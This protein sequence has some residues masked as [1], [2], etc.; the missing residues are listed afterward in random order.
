MYLPL[1]GWHMHKYQGVV[2]AI[3]CLV[4]IGSTVGVLH[5]TVVKGSGNTIWVDDDFIYPAESDGSVTKPYKTIKSALAVASNGDTIKVLPGTY[6][7]DLT[8]DKSITLVSEDATE[9]I[10]TSSQLNSY[11]IDIT[12]SSVSIEGFT[13]LD[14]TNTTHRRAVVHISSGVSDVVLTNNVINH[15]KDARGIFVNGAKSAIIT[16]NIINDTHGINVEHS[17]AT[18]IYGNTIGNCSNYPAIRLY[19]VNNNR[20]EHNNLLGSTYGVRVSSSSNVVISSNRIH[21]ND[22]GGLSIEGGSNNLI[23]TNT[24]FETGNGIT[25]SSQS[26]TVVG[27]DLHDLSI[28]LILD[29]SDCIVQDNAIQRCTTYGIYAKVGSK[30]N[31][32]FNN[33]FTEKTGQF[34]AK[35]QG[36]NQWDNGSCGN[37]WS[38]YYGPD[39]DENGIGE[40][41]YILGGVY[42]SCP[43]GIFQQ[44]PEIIEESKKKNELS[45]IP[46]HL[47]EGVSLQPTLSVIVSDPEGERMDVYFYYM[48]DNESHF[49][50]ANYNVES[51]SRASVPFFSTIQGQN[52]VYTYQ[53]TGYD[54]IG[55]WYVIVKDR[56]SETKSPE[57]IFSTKNVPIDNKRPTADAGGNH[58]GQIGDTIQFDGSGSADEDGTIEFYRWSFGDGTGVTNVESPTHQYAQAGEFVASLVIIDNNGA[59]STSTAK[60]EIESQKNRPPVAVINGPYNGQVGEVIQFLASGSYDPDPGDSITYSWNFGDGTTG[61]GINPTHNFSANGNYTIILTVTDEDGLANTRSTYCLVVAST[62]GTPGF[63]FIIVVLSLLLVSYYGYKKKRK[64]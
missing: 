5:S 54:Y 35:E 40:I 62:E 18:S 31:V 48:L 57:W 39:N 45:P 30:D 33:T 49:I 25:L 24:I 20:I 6:V 19:T 23:E 36:D 14:E 38:D 44:P 55:I 21:D 56:Y 43:I 27:N 8:I 26:S 42:D 22:Y 37:Y 13:F 7:G 47:A 53:G 34:H 63:E 15:S 50:A 9:T 60:V 28:G 64:N 32:M 3:V 51:G 2:W 10:I 1:R 29:S 4:V 16:N 59:S 58:K 17:D 11:M 46:Q 52:A 41:P 61:T 12:A